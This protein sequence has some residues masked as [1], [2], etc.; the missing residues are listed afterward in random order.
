MKSNEELR[1]CPFCQEETVHR[2]H[3]IGTYAGSRL[4][5]PVIAK[6]VGNAAK[7]MGAMRCK[8][9]EARVVV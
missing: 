7:I 8:R 4:A 1:W 6:G 2:P 5:D 9:C 3:Q